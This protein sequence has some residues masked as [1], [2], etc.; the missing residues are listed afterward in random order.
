M[1]VI[2]IENVPNVARVGEVKDVSDGYGR[3][4]LIPR[5][6]AV[7][8]TPSELQRLDAQIK[9]AKQR[10]VRGEAEAKALAQN[11]EELSIT[12]K[13]RAGEDD[14]LYGSITNAHIAEEIERLSGHEIPK[15][16]VVLEEPIRKLGVYEVTIKLAPGLSPKLKVT[17]E[18]EEP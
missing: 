18:K 10:Q 8:A 12:F 2:F 17:V 1:K 7:P 3:N 13:A 16:Q 5:K 15:R 6:L 14:R 11:L 4:Y 9:A